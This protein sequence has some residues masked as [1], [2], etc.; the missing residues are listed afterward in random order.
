VA[1][2]ADAFET[3]GDVA[4]LGV[5]RLRGLRARREEVVRAL[6]A[7]SGACSLPPFLYKPETLDR[8]ATRLRTAFADP[9]SDL[10]RAYVER[11]IESIVLT[12]GDVA[13]HGKAVDVVAA[14]AEK[15]PIHAA[16]NRRAKVRTY[17]VGWRPR[18][19]S[20]VRPAV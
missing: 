1:R 11:L 20:N 13:V 6:H 9:Q 4:E 5:E 14:M 17:V 19:D 15:G 8:F 3:G 7:L 16:R 2:W 18:D 12:D 10:A